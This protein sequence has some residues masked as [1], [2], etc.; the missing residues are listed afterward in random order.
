MHN[1][2]EQ[3]W[4]RSD[5]FE[6]IT[7]ANTADLRNDRWQSSITVTVRHPD[8]PSGVSA[9]TVYL[10][11]TLPGILQATKAAVSAI[12]GSVET[13]ISEEGRASLSPSGTGRAVHSEDVA[14]P[15]VVRCRRQPR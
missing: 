13:G 5:L 7:V 12:V 3:A 6:E 1:A 10:P 8:L 2:Q 15:R 9:G 4:D 14:V 11:I